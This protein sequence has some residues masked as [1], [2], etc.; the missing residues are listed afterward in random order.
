M[1]NHYL[2]KEILLGASCKYMCRKKESK[3]EEELDV[4]ASWT[5]A[6]L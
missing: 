3:K 4:L 2:L 1:L 6:H 5:Q